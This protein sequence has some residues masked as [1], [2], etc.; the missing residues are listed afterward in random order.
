MSNNRTE[1]VAES[2]KREL[3]QLIQLEVKDPRLGIVTVTAVKVSKDLSHAKVYVTFIQSDLNKPEEALKV[4]R[5]ASA[6]LRTVLSQ[7][8]KLRIAPQLNFV[9]DES[10]EH[11]R[12]LSNLIDGVAPPPE[13]E[14]K[15]E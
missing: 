12:H 15:H 9:Y 5:E 13:E 11:G 8:V 14:D 2:I 6:Y 10:I 7:R 4:L 3:A 1:R